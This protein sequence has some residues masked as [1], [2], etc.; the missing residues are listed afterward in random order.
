MTSSLSFGGKFLLRLWHVSN[1]KIVMMS[2]CFALV[3]VIDRFEMSVDYY[4]LGF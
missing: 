2:V 4:L 3:I 1:I